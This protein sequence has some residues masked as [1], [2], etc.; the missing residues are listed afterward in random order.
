MGNAK[1]WHLDGRNNLIPTADPTNFDL[2]AGVG[3][4]LRDTTDG[5]SGDEC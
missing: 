5:N 1:L 4:E 3:L 2:S